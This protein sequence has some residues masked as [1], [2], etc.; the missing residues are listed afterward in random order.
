MKHCDDS[1][2]VHDLIEFIL[3]IGDIDNT[4]M[5]LEAVEAINFETRVKKR[6]RKKWTRNIM[7]IKR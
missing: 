3:R 4:S 7:R 2:Y 6:L 5:N 1:I